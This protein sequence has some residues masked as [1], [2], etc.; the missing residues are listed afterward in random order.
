MLLVRHILAIALLPAMVAGLIPVWIARRN[1][2]ALSLGRT[3]I[4]GLAQGL[5]VV[6]LGVGLLLFLSSLRRF[7]NDGEGTLAPWDPPRK[8]VVSGPYRY[9]RN[10]MI[11]GVVFVL[12]GEA[13]VL[14][15]PP[16]FVWALTFVAIN[17]V[18]I[19]LL[20]EPQL[21]ARFGDVYAVYR[22][23]VPRLLPRSRPWDGA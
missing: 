21:I 16:H 2:I 14:L 3:L 10:P 4:A 20:E 23:H 18:Y 12:F 19:P 8:L 17:L 6:L 11:S 15:S 7:S 5:G 1:G 9:V 22:K 13:C